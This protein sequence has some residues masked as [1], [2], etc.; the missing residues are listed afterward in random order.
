MSVK[1]RRGARQ[2]HAFCVKLMQKGTRLD[3]MGGEGPFHCDGQE[4][5]TVRLMARNQ[6][7]GGF[8]IKTIDRA[9]DLQYSARTF[10]M[11]RGR[12]IAGKDRPLVHKRIQC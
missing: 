2:F 4:G 8:R 11:S 5:E 9:P 10:E 6:L 1:E 7:G 3:A 12:L